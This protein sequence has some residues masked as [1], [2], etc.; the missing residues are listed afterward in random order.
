MTF[1]ATANVVL[2]QGAEV[3]FVDI[4]EQT[5]NIDPKL[6]EKCPLLNTAD[7]AGFTAIALKSPP[8]APNAPLIELY[9]AVP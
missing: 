5:L 3:K 9:L 1:C 2:Y 8:S 4:D 7:P 6:I